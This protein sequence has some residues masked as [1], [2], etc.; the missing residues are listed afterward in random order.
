MQK[1]KLAK[2]FKA[3][4]ADQATGKEVLAAYAAGETIT[5][6]EMKK[7]AC[8]DV[9]SDACGAFVA[10]PDGRIFLVK[11]NRAGNV[12]E[13]VYFADSA[14]RKVRQIARHN[15]REFLTVADR[16]GFLVNGMIF[17]NGGADGLNTVKVRTFSV[18]PVSYLCAAEI[19][20]RKNCLRVDLTAGAKVWGHDCADVEKVAP[21]I[22]EQNAFALV[23]C[24]RTL[25]VCVRG[26]ED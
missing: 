10:L 20:D 24:R 25:W 23:F 2:K 21:I 15:D 3:Y 5:A 22:D 26:W 14:E 7:L 8:T 19:Y 16:A 9:G 6:A 4:G 18:R 13:V 11:K 1:I 17:P 12:A